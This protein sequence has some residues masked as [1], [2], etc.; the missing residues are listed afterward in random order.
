M[1]GRTDGRT[2]RQMDEKPK[3]LPPFL[4]CL[5]NLT[6][7]NGFTCSSSSFENLTRR[8]GTLSSALSKILLTM[9]ER[10]GPPSLCKAITFVPT[11]ISLISGSSSRTTP[12][13]SFKSH[14][15]F[16]PSSK[17]A[18]TLWFMVVISPGT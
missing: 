11:V 3:S 10:N 18:D 1:E 2:D 4:T 17:M 7:S 9:A 12:L 15:K 16:E 13:T 6:Y 8:L 14:E 5:N